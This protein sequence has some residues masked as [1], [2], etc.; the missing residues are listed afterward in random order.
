MLFQSI[1]W[2][3]DKFD[4]ESNEKY[5]A[6][7][8]HGIGNEPILG[9]GVG[10]NIEMKIIVYIFQLTIFVLLLFYSSVINQFAWV[11]HKFDSESIASVQN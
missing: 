9:W 7:G 4:S 8:C 6:L 11:K 2:E 1:A 3:K 5:M 10:Q